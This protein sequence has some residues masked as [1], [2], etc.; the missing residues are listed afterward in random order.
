MASAASRITM[1]LPVPKDIFWLPA[2]SIKLVAVKVVDAKVNPPMVPE[3]AVTA[4]AW[5]TEKVGEPV[6]PA[7]KAVAPE[8]TVVVL[9]PETA[10]K[11]V[12]VMV[13]PAMVP[14]ETVNVPTIVSVV[15]SQL[16]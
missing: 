15:P 2:S 13:K 7:E 9:P 3:V 6:G 12:A 10:V 16:R 8:E 14:E 1:L 4:P 5:V 11:V